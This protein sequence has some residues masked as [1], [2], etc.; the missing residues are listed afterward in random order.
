MQLRFWIWKYN[1]QRMCPGQS[2]LTLPLSR[3]TNFSKLEGETHAHLFPCPN[4]MA[5]AK[6]NE[7]CGELGKMQAAHC[8]LKDPLPAVL[9]LEALYWHSNMVRH[10]LPAWQQQ[11][12]QLCTTAPASPRWAWGTSPWWHLSAGLL[13]QDS[14]SGSPESAVENPHLPPPCAQIWGVTCPP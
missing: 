10:P 5:K 14:R 8:G 4:G 2:S 1:I 6:L 3:V 13:G 9:L 7:A 11:E 12:A